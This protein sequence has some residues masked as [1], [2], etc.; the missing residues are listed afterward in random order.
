MKRACQKCNIHRNI[1]KMQHNYCS[2]Q[3]LAQ[4]PQQQPSDDSTIL[5]EMVMCNSKGN[6]INLAKKHQTEF[7]AP[8]LLKLKR[9]C[10]KKFR[11]FKIKTGR[12]YACFFTEDSPLQER[13]L[14]GVIEI[15][16]D[17]ALLQAITEHRNRTKD[18]N[19]AHLRLVLS[20]KPGWSHMHSTFSF[21]PQEREMQKL[22]DQNQQEHRPVAASVISSMDKSESDPHVIASIA[23]PTWI[24]P[25]DEQAL[26]AYIL[27]VADREES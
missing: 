27:S 7:A 10:A 18:D 1:H 4:L 25:E 6:V 8:L 23:P 12:I 16:S 5:L 19:S 15:V 22:E 11:D 13:S 9:L 3:R 2:Q 26:Q 20:E 21:T 17:A 14:E 24:L